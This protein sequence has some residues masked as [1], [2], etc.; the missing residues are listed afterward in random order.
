MR[1]NGKAKARR[2]P[3]LIASWLQLKRMFSLIVQDGR[4]SHAPHIPSLQ[5]SN[6]RQGFVDHAEFI[7]LR[8][9]LPVSL[10]DPV[11]FLYL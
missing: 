1:P 6:T 8:D 2:T 11:T 3:A 9:N 7:A 5:E 10:R 4:L